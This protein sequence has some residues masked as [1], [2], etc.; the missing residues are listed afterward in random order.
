MI[1]GFVRQHVIEDA[2]GT[3]Y[4]DAESKFFDRLRVSGHEETP[5][6][7]MLHSW[8]ESDAQEYSSAE[9]SEIKETTD[10]PPIPTYFTIPSIQLESIIGWIGRVT[11]C[12]RYTMNYFPAQLVKDGCDTGFGGLGVIKTGDQS[13][14]PDVVVLFDKQLR[15]RRVAHVAGDEVET[16]HTHMHIIVN[17]T[18]RR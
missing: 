4:F 5:A 7:E 11:E 13:G 9:L 1:P 8:S 17:H 2:D 15:H 16:L 3:T 10:N 6:N 12:G 14:D 18:R